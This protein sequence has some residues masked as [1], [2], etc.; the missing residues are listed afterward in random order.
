MRDGIK[1]VF[2]TI[3]FLIL[4]VIGLAVAGLIT[5]PFRSAAGIAERTLAPD[6]VISNYEWFK[7]QY[8]EIQ[9]FESKI[10]SAEE[11]LDS[12]KK[13]V[14]SRGE[15]WSFGS[16][17]EYN[18]LNSV[19]LGLK[20]QRRDMIATYNAR[21]EMANRNLFRTSDLPAVITE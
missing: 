12:F 17:A 3:F 9:A 4:I 1:I 2:A 7:R 10:R 13:A 21:A 14:D 8:Q 11:S 16:E 15:G 5:L 20:S 18:R 6:N 19:V